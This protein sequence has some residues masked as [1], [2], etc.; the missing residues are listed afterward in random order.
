M[1]G[2]IKLQSASVFEKLSGFRIE[3]SKSDREKKV[4]ADIEGRTYHI[5][6]VEVPRADQSAALYATWVHFRFLLHPN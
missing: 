1:Y 2:S 3:L 5:C 4:R 6:H